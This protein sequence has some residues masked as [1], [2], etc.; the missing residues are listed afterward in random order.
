MENCRKE[1]KLNRSLKE[2]QEKIINC[3]AEDTKKQNKE[4]REIKERLGKGIDR[5]IELEWNLDNNG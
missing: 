4:N 1:I 3:L 5:R 2:T